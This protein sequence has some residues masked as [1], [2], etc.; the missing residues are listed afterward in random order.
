MRAEHLRTWLSVT[1]REESPDD[2]HWQKVAALVQAAF[3]EGRLA[4]ECMWQTVVLIPKG[5]SNLCGIGL[6]EVLR[7]AVS[8]ITNLRLNSA[9]DFH[10][11]LHGFCSGCV[12][13]IASLE[14]K[15]LQNLM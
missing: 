7:K 15:M 5:H 4:E 9:I 10:D 13:G 3:W 12:I 8:G 14:A 2:T 11:T 6:V 1:S